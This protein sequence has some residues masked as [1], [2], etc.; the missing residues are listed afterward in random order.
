M[1]ITFKYDGFRA[2]CYLEQ[3]RNRLISRNYNIMTRFDELAE[4]AAGV[5][6]VGDAI[7]DGEIIAADETGRPQFYDL[8]RGT[9]TPAY[10]AFDILWLNGTDLRSLPLSERRWTLQ[11][12]LPKASPIV[13][14]NGPNGPPLIL[15]RRIRRASLV[16]SGIGSVIKMHP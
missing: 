8:L 4:Q 6:E 3:R 15:S 7:L 11:S 14:A 12:I 9:R 5:L 2:L 10:I 1:P 13:S 16:S